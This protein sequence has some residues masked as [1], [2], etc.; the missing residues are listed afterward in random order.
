VAEGSSRS[1]AIVTGLGGYVLVDSA[2]T[3]TGT[4]AAF[5]IQGANLKTGAVV[6]DGTSDL[7]GGA[8]SLLAD[9]SEA[10]GSG[11]ARADT[12][13]AFVA[14]GAVLAGDGFDLDGDRALTRS[15]PSHCFG[16][17]RQHRV[18]GFLGGEGNRSERNKNR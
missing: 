16:V 18:G 13:V 7:A 10:D 5:A 9:A 3:L 11:D 14:G 8:E 6:C 2:E 15:E 17:L 1:P 4:S 12:Q